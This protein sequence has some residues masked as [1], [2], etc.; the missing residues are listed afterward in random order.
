MTFLTGA[1]SPIGHLSW[2]ASFDLD[3][4]PPTHPP[5]EG[6]TVMSRYKMSVYKKTGRDT[7]AY[8]FKLA[9]VI[10]RR[11]AKDFEA[12]GKALRG[13]PK[14]IELAEAE[15]LPRPA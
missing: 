10:L 8:D 15:K 12:R 11:Y 5:K 9:V 3:K 14:G 4:T 2:R 13:R 1:P 7:Y 6:G